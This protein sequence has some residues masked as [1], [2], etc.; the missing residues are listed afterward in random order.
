MHTNARALTHPLP[1][2]PEFCASASKRPMTAS[3]VATPRAPHSCWGLLHHN[4]PAP[5][6]LR[7]CR[8]P[9]AW[10]PPP[11]HPFHR[12]LCMTWRRRTAP[13]SP[14]A[15]SGSKAHRDTWQRERPTHSAFSKRR[16]VYSL[17]CRV[18]AMFK[19]RNYDLFHGGEGDSDS[20]ES[21]S[22]SSQSEEP[23][24]CPHLPCTCW[25]RWTAHA[26]ASAEV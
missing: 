4:S 12:R 14:S 21:S 5:Q 9:P 1:S 24:V 17:L 15:S 10:T 25:S 7:C 2:Q 23:G 22:S 3:R 26:A 19:R 16:Y 11:A 8:K 18:V 6:A 13:S 20:S